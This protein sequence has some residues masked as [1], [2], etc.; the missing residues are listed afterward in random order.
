[1]TGSLGILNQHMARAGDGWTFAGFSV[2][3]S[4]FPSSFVFSS[5]F[6]VLIFLVHCTLYSYRSTKEQSDKMMNQG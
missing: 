2:F 3:L 5:P 4:V 1:M 6:F